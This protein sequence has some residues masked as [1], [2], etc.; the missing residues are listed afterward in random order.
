MTRSGWWRAASVERGL[1]GRRQVDLVA[2][3]LQV[4]A[5]RAQDLGL[6]VDDEDA[7][8]RAA[9]Q[10]EHHRQPSARGVL[11]LH[12]ASDRLDEPFRHGEAESHSLAA[13]GVAEPL[14]RE[15]DPVALG[16]RGRPGPR[17][18]TRTSTVVARHAGD[19][20]HRAPRRGCG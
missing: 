2:A 10:A 20:A 7:R 11:E 4:R 17:S 18:T 6:V 1:A 13:A 9:L 5:E 16:R 15:E 8:H 14:E 12:L 19:D 3:R